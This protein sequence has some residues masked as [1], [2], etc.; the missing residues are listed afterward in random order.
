MPFG[1]S[2]A[3]SQREQNMKK[4]ALTGNQPRTLGAPKKDGWSKR[5][6]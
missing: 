1:L 2:Y 4:Y 5:M 3:S 6:L